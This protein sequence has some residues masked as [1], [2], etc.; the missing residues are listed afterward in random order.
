MLPK[1]RRLQIVS[2]VSSLLLV[3]SRPRSPS[4]SNQNTLRGTHALFPR[5]ILSESLSISLHMILGNGSR[6]E[7]RAYTSPVYSAF[8]QTV[9]KELINVL[10]PSGKGD[11]AK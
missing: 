2:S 8:I 4:L 6:E 7:V 10:N 3:S 9:E 11:P 1:L 5:E